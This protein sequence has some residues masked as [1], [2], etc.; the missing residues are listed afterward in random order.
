MSRHIRVSHLLVSS[1]SD[2]DIVTECHRY[3]GFTLSNELAEKN[4]T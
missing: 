4:E 1:S 2:M 3:F